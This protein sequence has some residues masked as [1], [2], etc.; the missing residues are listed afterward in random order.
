[1]GSKLLGNPNDD[2][3]RVPEL[4]NVSPGDETHAYKDRRALP[5]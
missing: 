2:S 1:M 4:L 3:F 5:V